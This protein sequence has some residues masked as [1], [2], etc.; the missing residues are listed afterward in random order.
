MKTSL[1]RFGLAAAALF[2]TQGLPVNAQQG[3]NVSYWPFKKGST[4]TLTTH[5]AE[6]T[7]DQVV[8]VT[9]VTAGNGYTTATLD[10]K[11]NGQ[12]V[13]GEKYQVSAAGIARAASGAGAASPLSP[14]MPVV[15]YPMKA[16]NAWK[17]KGT[18]TQEGNVFTCNGDLSVSGPE[19]IKTPGGTFQAMKVHLVLTMSAQGKQFTIPNDYWFAPNV[20]LIKQ[21]ANLNGVIIEGELK[22]YKLK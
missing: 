9:D 13:Q 12:S 17:W 3:K 5:V 6:R 22:S 11:V 15:K 19:T 4:W 20:G 8:T 14:P 18:L 2:V 10:Y 21:S 16:G 1:V 7:I